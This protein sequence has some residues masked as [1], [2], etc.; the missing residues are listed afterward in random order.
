[1]PKFKSALYLKCAIIQNYSVFK[2]YPIIQNWI[3][4]Y[5]TIICPWFKKILVLKNITAFKEVTK[6]SRQRSTVWHSS[7]SD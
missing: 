4:V 2:T 3:I 7:V 6:S 5:F 1:M